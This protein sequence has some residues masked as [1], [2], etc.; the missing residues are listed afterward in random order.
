MF[1]FRTSHPTAYQALLC[2]GVECVW[3]AKENV[4]FELQ[5]SVFY[6]TYGCEILYYR[7]NIRQVL[8]AENRIEPPKIG[9]KEQAGLYTR[10]PSLLPSLHR[11][12]LQLLWDQLT[13]VLHC[14]GTGVLFVWSANV[15]VL[16]VDPNGRM[17]VIVSGRGSLVFRW[18]EITHRVPV[19]CIYDFA[20]VC[21]CARVTG[22]LQSR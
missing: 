9:F 11:Y 3:F 4:C 14:T 8:L 22:C 15:V 5:K 16:S 18:S 10:Q 21:V 6:I 20:S 12:H 19:T 2:Y 13:L 1:S 7:P 17:I